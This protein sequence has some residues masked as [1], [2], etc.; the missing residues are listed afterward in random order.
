MDFKMIEALLLASNGYTGTLDADFMH[1]K[2]AKNS[3]DNFYAE[4]A[5][6][7][8]SAEKMPESLDEALVTVESEYERQGFISGFRMGARLMLECIGPA[9]L[10]AWDPNDIG[11]P[12]SR[13]R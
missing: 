2:G 9:P 6:V 10:E 8:L 13:V 7:G 1:L 11:N 5:K 4:L 12:V 3:T